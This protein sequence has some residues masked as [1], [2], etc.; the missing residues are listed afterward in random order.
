[1]TQTST[2]MTQAIPN[3]TRATFIVTLKYPLWE[4][5]EYSQNDPILWLICVPIFLK[6]DYWWLR[7]SVP[8]LDWKNYAKETDRLVR[9]GFLHIQHQQNRNFNFLEGQ[10]NTYT[11]LYFWASVIINTNIFQGHCEWTILPSINLILQFFVA[12]SLMNIQK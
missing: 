9:Y 7:Q 2:K 4:Y 8:K 1:M 6:S 10:H 3:V 11:S 5:K 12:Y